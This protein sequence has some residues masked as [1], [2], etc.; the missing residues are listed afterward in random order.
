MVPAS[1]RYKNPGA[2]WG[3]GN[4]VAAKW[5]NTST[6]TLNDGK[7]QGNNIATF[8]SYVN[9]IAAQLDLWRTSSHY[10]NKRF[11]I[12]INTWCGGNS[13]TQYVQH[14]VSRVPGLTASTVMNDDFWSDEDRAVLFL[15]TQA[16]MEAGQEYP[17]PNEDWHTAYKMVMKGVKPRPSQP[18]PA[19]TPVPKP[20]PAAPKESLLWKLIK[21][22]LGK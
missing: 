2:M 12:A 6:V 21:I 1:I 16:S 17:A 7:G 19:P 14:M 8:P 5:G 22:L 10:K 15:K 4:P 9:G 20:V 11:D 18:A 13:H 3:Q